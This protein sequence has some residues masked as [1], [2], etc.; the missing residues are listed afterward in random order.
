WRLSVVSPLETAAIPAGAT[1]PSSIR[2]TAEGPAARQQLTLEEKAP[3]NFGY[4]RAWVE[5]RASG[6][7]VRFRI[8]EAHLLRPES[9]VKA[10]LPQPLR[11][12]FPRGEG[13]AR[14]LFLT[15]DA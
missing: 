12:V 1:D 4:L 11:K 5:I 14:L 9:T 13:V 10:P 2:S 3:E 7:G 8:G 15:R 6:K